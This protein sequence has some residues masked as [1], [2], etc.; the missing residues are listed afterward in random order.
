MKALSLTV[1]RDKLGRFKAVHWDYGPLAARFWSKVDKSE[2]CWLWLGAK[3][4]QGYG[5]LKI[6]GKMC[7]ANRIT[8]ELT[9]GSI[10]PGLI[11][12]HSCDNPPCVNPSHLILSTLKQNTQ[13]MM[14]KGRQ[15]KVN[16]QAAQLKGAQVKKQR[17]LGKTLPF[18]V[19]RIKY[20]IESG[21]KP[22]LRLCATIPGY[23]ALLGHYMRH[24]EMVAMAKGGESS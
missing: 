15:G 16:Y 23:N 5:S 14:Q 2:E 20:I 8:F 3:N 6:S 19:A 1:E 9:K 24:N 18:V 7:R 10:P 13:D 17:T 22:T 4:K 12:R 21:T 11:V